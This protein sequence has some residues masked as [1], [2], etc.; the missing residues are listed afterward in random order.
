MTSAG[1]S[2]G[3][4]IEKRKNKMLSRIL[5]HKDQV[6]DRYLPADVSHRFRELLLREVNDFAEVNAFV[7]DAALQGQVVN[8]YVAD[9]RDRVNGRERG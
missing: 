8:E 3:A 7:I 4:F 9:L 2:A 6:L 1:A 5:T